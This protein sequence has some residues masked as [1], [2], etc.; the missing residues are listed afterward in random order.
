MKLFVNNSEYLQHTLLQ[1]SI[2]TTLATSNINVITQSQ[3][4]LTTVPQLCLTAACSKY[5]NVF[6]KN[7]SLQ[8]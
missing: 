6:V 5:S 1:T 3:S 7:Q 8:A 2:T 4:L